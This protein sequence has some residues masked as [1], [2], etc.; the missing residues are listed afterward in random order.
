[1]YLSKTKLEGNLKRLRLSRTA[2]LKG[3]SRRPDDGARCPVANDPRQRERAEIRSDTRAPIPS[4]HSAGANRSVSEIG[5]TR[6]AR[7]SE[8]CRRAEKTSPA[9]ESRRVVV[10][11]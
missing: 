5:A 1:M 2:W 10:V 7:H 4:E 6:E 9:Q 8:V 3:L 11:R